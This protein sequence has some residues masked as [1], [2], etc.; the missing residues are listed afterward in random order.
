MVS[1]QPT[2]FAPAERASAD[3]LHQQTMLFSSLPL[4]PEFF[5]TIPNVMMVLNQQRQIVFANRALLDLLGLQT[6]ADVVGHRPGEALDCVHA[7][8]TEG[9]CGTTE[10]CRTCGAVRTILASLSG[11]KATNECRIVQQDGT[12]L[13]LRV[14][15]TPLEMAGERYSVF[16][17]QDISHEKRRHAL[18]RIFFHDLLNTAQILLMGSATLLTHNGHDERT[19][20]IKRLL[21]QAAN[22]LIDE[23]KSQ[24]DL[25][26]AESG[27]LA[28]SLS[29][30]SSLQFLREIQSLYESDA[31]AHGRCVLID[32]G[33][34][35]IMITS[36]WTLL[37]RVIRNMV[38][39]A[40]EACDP[41][42]SVTL[43]CRADAERISFE[44]HNPC[45][46]PREVQLQIFQ[47]SFSTKGPG[48]GL[49]TYSMKLLSEKFLGGTV[50]FT[51]TPETGTIFMAT[52]PL[53][54][55]FE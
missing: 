28:V 41:G 39:N 23:I 45:F 7:T 6:Q 50:S 18:E 26:W 32:P 51:S 46:I 54:L 30:F 37:Q 47:R 55:D 29:T 17:V 22:R 36:D 2:M 33:A 9:G 35:D 27:D 15:G 31:A 43:S 3:T 42:Q 1:I 49:G 11:T 24:R 21:H 20:D 34:V 8:E 13:D 25:L 16:A 4:L 12:A 14:W 19:R 52:Y 10:F 48:R 53:V 44:V 38:K 40:L 5:D